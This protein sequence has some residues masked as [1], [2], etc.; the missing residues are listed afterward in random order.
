MNPIVNTSIRTEL[1]DMFPCEFEAWRECG[2]DERHVLSTA[3]MHF[4]DTPTGWL[5]NAEYRCEF[6]GL[7]PV[8]IRYTAPDESFYLCLCSPGEV[9]AEWLAVLISADGSFVREVLRAETFSPERF[10]SLLS[11]AGSLCRTEYSAHGTAAFLAEEV[12]L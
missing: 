5:A 11:A 1:T 3:V 10:N 2:D 9:C 4:L 6:G 12:T 7:F 8:Q